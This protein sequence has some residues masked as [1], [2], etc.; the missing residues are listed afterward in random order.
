VRAGGRPRD[1][2]VYF[3][4]DARAHAPFDALRRARRLGD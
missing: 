3:D 2:C 1:V 4:N